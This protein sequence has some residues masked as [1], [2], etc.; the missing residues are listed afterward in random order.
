MRQNAGEERRE[1]FFLKLERREKGSPSACGAEECPIRS[2]AARAL[3]KRDPNGPLTLISSNH[4]LLGLI[5]N[6]RIQN[7]EME[8]KTQK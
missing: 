4:E 7:A 5:W 1:I 2:W 6:E 8:K 3:G